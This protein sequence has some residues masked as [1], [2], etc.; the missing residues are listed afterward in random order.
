MMTLC[1][2][3]CPPGLRGFISRWLIEVD[4]GV[5]VGK[6]SRRV[7]EK[8]WE[9][10]SHSV[11]YGSA[12]MTHSANNEQGFTITSVGAK[13]EIIN[14]DGMTLVRKPDQNNSSP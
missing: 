14:M 12:V 2:S 9:Q 8:L 1:I 10:V 3:K 4:T 11:R 13:W 7:R 5:F 6:V